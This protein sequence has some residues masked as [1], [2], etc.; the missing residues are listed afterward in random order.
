MTYRELLGKMDNLQDLAILPNEGESGGC[1]SSYDRASQYDAASDRYLHW[2]ANEDGSGYIRKTENG[3]IVAFECDGPGCIF[4]TWSALPKDG[5]IQ[6]FIDQIT[7]P[8]V[9]VPFK[10]FFEK[11]EGDIPPLNLSE[12]SMNLS[13][14]RNC[15]IPIPFQKYCRIELAPDW[16]AYY[17]FTYLRY[18]V[19][20]QMPAYTERFTRDGMIALAELDRRLY[21][22]ESA[23]NDLPFIKVR[24]VVNSG[25]E[26]M[27]H[28][29]MGPG[30]IACLRFYPDGLVGKRALSHMLIKLYWDGE[31]K[32]SVEAPIDSFFGSAPGMHPFSCLP[33]SMNRCV[34]ECRFFMPYQYGVR[35]TLVNYNQDSQPVHFEIAQVPCAH[36]E[37]LLRF[38]AKWHN[39]YYGRLSPAD[40]APNGQ[41]WPD[42]PILLVNGPGRFCGVHLHI[43]NSWNKPKQDAP[44][45]WYG[46]WDKKNV[47]WWWGEGDEKF[48][49][50]NEKFP[51]SFG[52]GSEDYIGYA[53]AAEP[54]FARF[55][56]PFSCL[57]AMPIDG[58][59]HT[60]V[61]RFQI[62]DHIP[63]LK[64]F[65]GYIEKY[66][67]NVWGDDNRCLYAALPYWYQAAN[68]T[69]DYP[70]IRPDDLRLFDGE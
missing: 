14:G 56:S 19:G 54:P 43:Y 36:A 27:I 4:R 33:L 20:T 24:D 17:H 23:C 12:L 39:G 46:K 68:T 11:Q 70:A 10:D 53:W 44:D 6:I 55:Q 5:H 16:G 62:A 37:S 40:F 42:W 29:S 8:V 48:F 66:K 34:F 30:A 28:S 59:G 57:N 35:F 49:I 64:R 63:F 51:S 32:P 31:V 45:W 58:N 1:M 25:E 50:D 61:C 2:D 13:R 26:K 7:L 21:D 18:P 47:D 38:H 67:E 52:T 69:D 9:D 22:R 15:F 3:N 65:E 60:S 41:R